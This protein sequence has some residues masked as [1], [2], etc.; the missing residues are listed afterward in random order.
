MS[1]TPKNSPRGDFLKSAT[2]VAVGT[3]IATAVHCGE[4]TDIIVSVFM[5]VGGGIMAY[6]AAEPVATGLG[7]L[8]NIPDFF[9]RHY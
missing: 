1:E 5:G 3:G 4:G 7:K 2:G 8:K 6:A 9:K